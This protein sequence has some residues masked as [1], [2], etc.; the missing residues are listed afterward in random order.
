MKLGLVVGQC[1][2]A[3][4][5]RTLAPH[6]DRDAAARVC[7]GHLRERHSGLVHLVVADGAQEFVEVEFKRTANALEERPHHEVVDAFKASLEVH[8]AEFEE[9]E[10]LGKIADRVLVP[11]HRILLLVDERVHHVFERLVKNGLLSR[12]QN[13]R[14]RER[15]GAVACAQ[16]R[17]ERQQKAR[18]VVR[19]FARFHEPALDLLHD[20]VVA[21]EL[22]DF[23]VVPSREDRVGCVVQV[24]N[25]RPEEELGVGWRLYNN[26]RAL[27]GTRCHDDARREAVLVLLVHEGSVLVVL[28]GPRD[29]EVKGDAVAGRLAADPGCSNDRAMGG[30][31]VLG[32]FL[33]VGRFDRDL[34]HCIL[35][36]VRDVGFADS[37]GEPEELVEDLAEDEAHRR[38][39]LLC[40]SGQLLE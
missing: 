30:W 26:G 15:H 20:F 3:L 23:W 27:R 36:Q 19:E 6:L 40:V 33:D 37:V 29:F 5:R 7:L 22:V 17:Q 28:H 11:E 8:G 25:N 31:E 12:V 10:P 9:N 34:D 39:I 35:S 32:R 1:H 24:V 2:K 18:V 21:R 4:P 14:P 13:E 16:G 38:A